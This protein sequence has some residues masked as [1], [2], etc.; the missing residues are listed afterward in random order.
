MIPP[1]RRRC[2]KG[3]EDYRLNQIERSITWVV[4][5]RLARA[6]V[7]LAPQLAKIVVCVVFD[8]LG[9]QI[10][11]VM[12]GFLKE[13]RLRGRDP[14]QMMV[15]AQRGYRLF[16]RV[17]LRRRSQALPPDIIAGLESARLNSKMMGDH[18]AARACMKMLAIHDES[19]K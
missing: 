19:R 10:P 18:R 2:R 14:A 1:R 7:P 13:L 17:Q 11:G 8:V 4:Y 3:T 5:R 6:G 9:E 16:R 12:E 15:Q